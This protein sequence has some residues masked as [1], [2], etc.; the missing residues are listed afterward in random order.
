M[1][2]TINKTL[3]SFMWVFLGFLM[4]ALIFSIIVTLFM[5]TKISKPL[6]RLTEFSSALKEGN[7]SIQIDANLIQNRTEIG[8]L[9]SGFEH[10]RLNLQ[11]LVDDIQKVSKEVLSSSHELE[12][13]SSDTVTAGENVSRNVIEIAKG[14]SEQ[15]ENTESGTGDVIKLGQLIEENASSSEQVTSIV[16]GIIDAMNASASSAKA[17]YQIASQLNER[18]NKF[19]L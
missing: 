17:L 7:L 4:L 18:A 16:T 11:S 8:K 13:I 10:M 2:E 14:A 1:E 19:S 3:Y 6:V 15:A 9:A 5:G 12:G